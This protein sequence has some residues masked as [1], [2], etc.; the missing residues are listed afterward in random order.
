MRES[1][2][3]HH[4]FDDEGSLILHERSPINPKSIYATAKVAADFLTMNYHD[5][6]GVPGVV[7]RMFNNYGPRQN[8]RYVTGTI[9]TQALEREH[10][11]LGALEPL[12]DFCFCTDGVRGHLMVAAQGVPGD[13]YVYGQGKNIS[14]A[15]WADMILRIGEED[16]HWTSRTIVTNQERFRPGVTDVMALRVGYEKL[17][18]ETGWEP[19]VSWEDGI[20]KTIEWYA[21]NRERWI[22]RVDWLPYTAPTVKTRM[23]TL[24]TGGGGFLGTHVVERLQARGDRPDRRAQPRLR[25]DALG[26]R[27]AALPRHEAGARAAPRGRGRRDRREPRQPGPLLVRE[28]DDGRAR[29]RAVA[30]AR[31]RQARRARDG[32]RVPEVRAGAVPRGRSLERL[33]R[34][35]ERAV[36]RREEVAARRRA[37]LPRAVRAERDLPP[38][39]EPLRARRQLR[40]RDVARDPGADPQDARGRRARRARGRALG[41]RLADARV[42]LRRGLRR[43]DR[44]RRAPLRRP[45]SRSTSAPARRSRSG[46]SPS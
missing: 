7:T 46:T 15:D 4:D 32:L 21:A 3:H 26:R 12:R 36:R 31:R 45:R 22:G 14:M 11:E 34:G 39:R 38:A 9:I 42:P 44:A 43:R 33:P 13:L 16:G 5:A 2:A 25:P 30:P 6:Y 35:D 1:V 24:V 37:D 41:R 28:P 27:R 18:R 29:A 17:N 23:R 10:V 20:R 19:Q 40:P 8:P